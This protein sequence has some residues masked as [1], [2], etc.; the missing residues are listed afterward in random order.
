M[1]DKEKVFHSMGIYKLLYT[2]AGLLMVVAFLFNS[3]TEIFNGLITIIKSPCTLIT[4]YMYLANIGAAFFNAGLICLLSTILSHSFNVVISGPGVAAVFTMTG[5]AFFGKNIF[6]TIPI[7]IGVLIYAKIE[8]TSRASVILPALFGSALGP[9]ISEIAF[10][11]NLSIVH[12][13]I[14]S[15]LVGISIGLIMVPLSGTFLRF[16]QG[17]NL[18]N[19]GFTAGIVGMLYVGILRMF[20]VTIKSVNL[21]Y[22]VNDIRII[23]FLYLLFISIFLLGFIKNNLSFHGYENIM[24]NSGRLATDFISLDGL[25]QTMI[26]MGIMGLIATSYIIIVGGKISGPIIGGIFTVT[27]FSAFGKHPKNTIPILIGV[28]LASILNTVNPLSTSS[29]LAA[30]FGTTLAPIAGEFGFFRGIL[31]GF[32]HMAMVLNIGVVHGGVNLYNNGFSGGFVAGILV[33]VFSEMDNFLMRVRLKN[34][35]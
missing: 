2:L 25:Y 12:S 8:N 14:L 13:I 27:G 10:D 15:Y 4:D 22:P 34:D 16:H 21:V 24:Y 5:F 35:D 19:M 31:A 26:N 1:K 11:S 18:Y 17:Y 32:L 6:N 30:L 23:I 29:L 28:F 20:N 7:T 33:P 9:L 3:P